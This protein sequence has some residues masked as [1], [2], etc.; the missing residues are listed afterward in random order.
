MGCSNTKQAPQG[1]LLE[2]YS[3]AGLVQ[4][5]SGEYQNDFEKQIYMAINLCR[6][7]PKRFVPHVRKVYK[8]HPLLAGGV[9]KKMTELVSKLNTAE[10]LPLVKFDGQ[11]NEACLANNTFVINKDE[12]TPT[13]G[14]NIA[15][16]SELSGSD[17]SDSCVE[18]TMPKFE[19]TT[20]EEFVALQLALNFE[21]LDKDKKV[22]ATIEGAVNDEA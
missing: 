10:P 3:A 4:P 7:D 22:E 14:G 13:K 20:G 21:D 1:S 19:G 8:D 17:K 6:H 18:F 11:A 5:W 2:Q 15:K 16:L 12:V 9:G